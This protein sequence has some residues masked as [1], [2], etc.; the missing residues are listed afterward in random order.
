MEVGGARGAW[1]GRERARRESDG[2]L[3]PG[4]L[5]RPDHPLRVEA[6]DDLRPR[7]LPHPPKHV[8]AVERGL[9]PRR[10]GGGVVRR[11]EEAGDAVLE[12]LAHR[13]G[14]AGDEQAAAVL[15]ASSSDQERTK[16]TVR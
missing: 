8:A 16:G 6:A 12:E 11:H 14:V 15:I 2:G 13:G 1:R 10:E 9:D 3:E 5:L 7:P 4:A